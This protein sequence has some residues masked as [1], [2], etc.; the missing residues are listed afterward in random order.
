MKHYNL[1]YIYVHIKFQLQRAIQNNKSIDN[2]KVNKLPA[3]FLL[4]LL[5]FDIYLETLAL[6]ICAHHSI[7]AIRID[8]VTT[9]NNI[10]LLDDKISDSFFI[11]NVSCPIM[12]LIH[13]SRSKD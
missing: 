2:C 5:F 7:I 10:S 13:C 6:F 9:S 1:T 12:F 8:S 3:V 4:L 11:R